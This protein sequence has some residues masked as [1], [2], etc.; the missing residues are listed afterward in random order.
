MASPMGDAE[1]PMGDAESPMTYEYVLLSSNSGFMLLL[2]G[3]EKRKVY[4]VFV[5]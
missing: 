5:R 2:T 3:R 4:K 1:S